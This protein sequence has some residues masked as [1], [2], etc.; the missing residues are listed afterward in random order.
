MCGNMTSGAIMN[1]TEAIN[2]HVITELKEIL[3]EEFPVLV[4]TYL[5]DANGRLLRLQAAIERRDA[6]GVKMEA[7][8][9]K[10]SSINLGVF[11][12]GC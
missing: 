5:Q 6:P 7:H 11:L 3:A 1:N 9:L 8:S 4:T 2:P 10:G 12:W